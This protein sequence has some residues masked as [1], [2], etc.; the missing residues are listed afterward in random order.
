[1]PFSERSNN[2]QFR[3]YLFVSALEPEIHVD[4]ISWY[5]NHGGQCHEP[6]YSLTPAW[7]HIVSHCERNHLYGAEQEHPLWET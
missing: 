3:I 6:A 4:H 7:E 2:T 5:E 1:M